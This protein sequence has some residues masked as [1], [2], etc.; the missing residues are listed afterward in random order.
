M[1]EVIEYGMFTDAGDQA[2]GRIVEL[3][4]AQGLS[5]KVTHSL[6]T[7]LS[8]DERFGEATDTA[9]REYVYDALDFNSSFYI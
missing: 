3:A 8:E 1:I 7:A 4:K 9:V 2:V 5:W 6:L